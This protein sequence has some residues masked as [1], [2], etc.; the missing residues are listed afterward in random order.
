MSVSACPTVSGSHRSACDAWLC[1]QLVQLP[2]TSR[3][4]P[5]PSKTK[6]AGSRPCPRRSSHDRP[7][8][9]RQKSKVGPLLHLGAGQVSVIG[10][11]VEGDDGG[12]GEQALSQRDPGPLAIRKPADPLLQ[13]HPE[14]PQQRQKLTHPLAGSVEPEPEGVHHVVHCVV[15]V[16]PRVHHTSP[17][18]AG[19]SPVT[20]PSRVVLPL[21]F[22]PMTA[23]RSPR[24]SW[25]D[26]Y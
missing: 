6:A 18:S 12:S 1:C 11:L 26:S 10:W 8:R 13:I 4:W 16:R 23:S 9:H 22:G 3:I 24:L 19:S 21:P 5:L 17:S 7:P 2:W 20:A 15:Q 14:E 25:K